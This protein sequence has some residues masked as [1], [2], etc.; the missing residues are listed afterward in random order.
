MWRNNPLTNGRD[1]W[2]AAVFVKCSIVTAYKYW[3]SVLQHGLGDEEGQAEA[4]PQAD[5]DACSTS[6]GC[7]R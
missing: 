6:T 2:A 3:G 4:G 5:A 7:R 1:F